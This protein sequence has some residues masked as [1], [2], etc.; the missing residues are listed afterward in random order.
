MAFLEQ[1]LDARIE[2]GASGG[3]TKAGQTYLINEK[4]PELWRSPS[5]GYMFPTQQSRALLEGMSPNDPGGMSAAISAVLAAGIGGR[6]VDV[7][8]I[9]VDARGI[10]NPHAMAMVTAEKLAFKIDLEDG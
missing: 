6:S 5:D 9:H 8:G 3:P 4:G 10:Q 2:Q 7:G 1:R